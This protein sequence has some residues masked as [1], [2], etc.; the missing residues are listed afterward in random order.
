MNKTVYKNLKNL[1]PFTLDEDSRI[2]DSEYQQLT[3]LLKR[4][5]KSN[6][7]ASQVSELLKDDLTEKL[8]G[9]KELVDDVRN[10]K[11]IIKQDIETLEVGLLEYFDILDDLNKV[12]EKSDDQDFI[13]ATSVAIKAKNQINE[14]LGI[15]TIPV[16]KGISIDPDVHYIVKSVE[17]NEEKHDSTVNHAIQN[18]YR[19]GNRLLRKATVVSNVYKGD[20]NE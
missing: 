19:R 8:E 5:S 3:S 17:V 13:N 9:Y 10:E 4:I 16:S 15:Q 6:Q 11:N 2:D 1:K 20:N 12:A 7:K 14:R 18:G